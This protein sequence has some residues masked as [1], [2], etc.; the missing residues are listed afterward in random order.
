[1][2]RVSTY[3]NFKGQTEEAFRY[4]AKV[5]GTEITG[6]IF[7]MGD[8]PGGPGAPQLPA[9]E[10]DLVMHIELPILADHILMG[11]DMVESLGQKVKV[12]NNTT[13]NLEPD[14][15]EEANRLYDALSDGGSESTGM[16]QQ[17]WGYWGC[18]LDR[19]GIRWMVNFAEQSQA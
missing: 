7:R 10:K 6:P 19:F 2:S 13:I 12:G 9:A 5:F 17:P 1:M 11:T 14:S 8:I 15:K 16:Q 4:Y 18:T 3:L